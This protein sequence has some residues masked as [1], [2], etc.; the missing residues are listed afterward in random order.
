VWPL[1]RVRTGRNCKRAGSTIIN[2]MLKCTK[3]YCMCGWG[4]MVEKGLLG[5]Q[6]ISQ[7]RRMVWLPVFS[8]AA[9]VDI[10][11]D[12]LL[13]FFPPQQLFPREY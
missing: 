7:N 5:I 12:L 4:N 9:E 13:L 3:L 11:I 8:L 2:S 1:R 10:C 6:S